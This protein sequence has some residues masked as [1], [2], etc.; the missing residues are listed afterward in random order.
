M[1]RSADDP[2]VKM[3]EARH[4]HQARNALPGR[5]RGHWR[6]SAGPRLPRPATARSGKFASIARPQR[7]RRGVPTVGLMRV[8]DVGRRAHRLAGVTA[9]RSRG[10]RDELVTPTSS[11]SSPGGRRTACTPPGSCPREGEP[12]IRR[13]PDGGVR[14]GALVVPDRR[15][16]RPV[17]IDPTRC[18]EPPAAQG[19]GGRRRPGPR[20]AGM[21]AAS[22]R[23][24]LVRK[25]AR[26]DS[27]VPRR[28]W[29][30]PMRCLAAG[31]TGPLL[32]RPEPLERLDR[33]ARARAARGAG[34][35]P[36]SR[37]GRGPHRARARVSL[38]RRG[39]PRRRP[40]RA[41]G[42]DLPAHR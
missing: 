5:S 7:Q 12:R 40:P 18:A 13:G 31:D 23:A 26:H 33:L 39:G 34:L 6:T 36:P 22:G 41:G 17:Y 35:R 16:R 25:R 11:T 42:R 20:P 14:T 38:Q 24:R 19:A 10:V 30:L 29:W 37:R 4:K 32:R 8:P 2:A 9:A 27:P 28:T 15:R 3:G 1:G 21:T